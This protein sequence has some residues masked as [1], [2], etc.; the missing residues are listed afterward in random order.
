MLQPFLD[1]R[2]RELCASE[3]IRPGVADLAFAEVTRGI[4]DA[5]LQRRRLA[6]RARAADVNAILTLLAQRNL[7]EVD[8]DAGGHVGCRIGYLVEQLFLGGS[9]A[10]AASRGVGLAEHRAAILLHIG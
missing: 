10:D 6:R 8:R 2:S 5:D 3:R 1:D 4:A 7:A 9:Q